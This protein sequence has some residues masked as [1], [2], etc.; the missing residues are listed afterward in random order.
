VLRLSSSRAHDDSQE[1]RVY[2]SILQIYCINFELIEF[3]K[4]CVVFRGARDSLVVKALGY[5]PE[6]RVG[7][8]PDEVKF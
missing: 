7:S 6:G 4:V 3:R 1:E 5:K 8:R 2:L